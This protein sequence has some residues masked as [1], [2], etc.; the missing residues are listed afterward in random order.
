M[1][2]KTIDK[3]LEKWQEKAVEELTAENK[4]L[5][6]DKVISEVTSQVTAELDRRL[7][8]PGGQ[9]DGSGEGKLFKALESVV[10]DY[11]EKRL[12]G[13]GA[14]GALTSDQI[15]NVVREEVKAVAGGN[16]KPED[17]VDDIVNAVTMGDKLRDRLGLPG[18]GGRLLSNQGG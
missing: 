11:L 12:L 4:G 15:R 3:T 13:G 17:M 14:E 7:P 16:K 9:G 1:S 18:L 2:E 6:E 10:A 5:K 8:K